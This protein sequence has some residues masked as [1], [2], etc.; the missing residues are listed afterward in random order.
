MSKLNALLASDAVDLHC[1]AANWRE[2]L[3]QAGSLLEKTGAITPEYTTAMV[4]SVETNGPYIVVAPGFAF[5]H[6]RP[7]S[8][9]K[10]GRKGQFSIRF[11]TQWRICFTWKEGSAD[12]VELV[13]YH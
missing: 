12:H 1:H 6:A 10:G 8:A 9:V 13:D 2:A 3:T 4:E 11:N 7:S 5:A